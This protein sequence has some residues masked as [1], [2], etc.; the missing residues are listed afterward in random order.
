MP[1]RHSPFAKPLLN[2][3]NDGVVPNAELLHRGQHYLLRGG[4]RG[5]WGVEQR[6]RV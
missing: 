5:L 4:S 3:F 1:I 2:Y 6:V